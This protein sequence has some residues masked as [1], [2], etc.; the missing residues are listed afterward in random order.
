MQTQAARKGER[1]GT[2]EWVGRIEV[3]LRNARDW[4]IG[5][6]ELEL[7]P[8]TVTARFGSRALA[9]IDREQLREWVIH[10]RGTRLAVDDLVWSAQ[11]GSTY[12]AIGCTTEYRLG[13]S[14]VRELTAVV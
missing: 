5:I 4:S 3:D 10:P 8:E 13:D 14:S 7:A 12:V 9:V 11:Y 6:L 1:P 2:G